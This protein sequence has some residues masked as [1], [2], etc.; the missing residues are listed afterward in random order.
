MHSR[1]AH[2]TNMQFFLIMRF[3]KKLHNRKLKQSHNLNDRVP[4]CSYR[5]IPNKG[6]PFWQQ[7]PY[8]TGH[9]KCTVCTCKLWLWGHSQQQ[10]WWQ[11]TLKI[12][13]RPSLGSMLLVQYQLPYCKYSSVAAQVKCKSWKLIMDQ[14]YLSQRRL[15]SIFRVDCHQTFLLAVAS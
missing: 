13:I 12:E 5:I 7:F 9:G 15:N 6:A 11:S 2:T 3:P 8:F 1:A 4:F 10:P 14:Q